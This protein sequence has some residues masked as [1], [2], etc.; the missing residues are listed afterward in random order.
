MQH[1]MKK[2]SHETTKRVDSVQGDAMK[3]L[4]GYDWPGNV[5]E[6]ANAIERAVLLSRS[7]AL[8]RDDLA[9]L[10]VSPAPTSRLRPLREME[11]NHIREI[12]IDC[13]WNVTRAAGILDINRG[14]LHKM[15]NR[16][17]LKRP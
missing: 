11:R 4:E 8:G 15:I 17:N 3:L 14:T 13:D 7:R 12:L 9:F 2:Y 10:C 16:Y 5:R 6:L 1:F